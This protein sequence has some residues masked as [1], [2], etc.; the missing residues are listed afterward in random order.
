[1]LGGSLLAAGYVVDV[2][3]P[4]GLVGWVLFLAGCGIALVGS[5]RDARR[6]GDRIGTAFLRGLKST[7]RW[8][9][10]FLP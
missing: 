5:T 9:V 10:D 2:S 1:M 4:L 7:F 6:R 8:I 3:A